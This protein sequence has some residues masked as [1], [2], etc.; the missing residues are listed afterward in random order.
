MYFVEE[1]LPESLYN[2]DYYNFLLER[3]PPLAFSDV[4]ES[5]YLSLEYPTFTNLASKFFSSGELAVTVVGNY[6]EEATKQLA[7]GVHQMI[8]EA[9]GFVPAGAESMPRV[10][11]LAL[12]QGW[13]YAY[14]YDYSSVDVKV[15]Y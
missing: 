15:V 13:G 1:A 12:P 2:Y 4:L 11:A 3:N 10:S 8:R 7:R 5:L 6:R 9:F 14:D